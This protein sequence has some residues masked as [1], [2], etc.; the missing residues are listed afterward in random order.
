[1][2]FIAGDNNRLTPQGQGEII[3]GLRDLT[4][5][6]EEYPVPFKYMLNLK[7]K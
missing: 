6:G 3:A 7:F 4:F 1:M 5:M 2:F